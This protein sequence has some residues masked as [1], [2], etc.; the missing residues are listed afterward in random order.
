[1]GAFGSKLRRLSGDQVAFWCPGCETVHA[2]TVGEGKSPRWGFNQ[3]GD[4]PTFTPSVLVTYPAN[5]NAEDDFAEWRVERRC[6]SFVTLGRIEFLAD[7]TH[8]L[9]GQTVDLP[10][11]PPAFSD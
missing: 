2:L 10:D 3:S 7:S 9:A 6:H 5:P 11:F 1:M 8:N 4:Q